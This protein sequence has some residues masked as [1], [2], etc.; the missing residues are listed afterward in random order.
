[1]TIDLTN[2]TALWL[3]L[4]AVP[5]VLFYLVSTRPRRQLVATGFL[6]A[7]AVQVQRVRSWWRPWRQP[8]SLVVQL[9]VLALVVV[10][11]AGPAWDTAWL[12]APALALVA[13]EWCLFQRRW[14]C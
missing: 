2:P 4:L 14:T 7:R 3:A 1:V 8:V 13:I 10:A 9:A 12:L 5:I 11:A 6:W